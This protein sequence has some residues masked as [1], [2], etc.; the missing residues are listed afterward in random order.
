MYV[1]EHAGVY[2]NKRFHVTFL[3][4]PVR[5]CSGFSTIISEFY[6]PLLIGTEYISE[7]S[8][9]MPVKQVS[10]RTKFNDNH[11]AEAFSENFSKNPRENIQ[12]LG[13]LFCVDGW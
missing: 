1:P 11:W 5:L 8:C 10:S 12:I 3:L 13:H 6:Y 7:L 9:P 2:N 4:E